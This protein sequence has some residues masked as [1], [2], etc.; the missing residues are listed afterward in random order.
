[1]CWAYRKT[2]LQSYFSSQRETNRVIPSPKSPANSDRRF[3]K[4]DEMSKASLSDFLVKQAF[5][6]ASSAYLG[7]GGLYHGNTDSHPYV[8]ITILDR[9]NFI[10][11]P[12]VELPV[13]VSSAGVSV[14][15]PMNWHAQYCLQKYGKPTPGSRG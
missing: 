9:K 10:A 14:K 6:D 11:K 4:G 2:I 8:D 15:P 3:I 7:V 13:R 12:A 5:L 1:M